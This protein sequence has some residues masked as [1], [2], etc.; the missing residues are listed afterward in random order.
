MSR[1]QPCKRRNFVRKLRALGFE[2]PYSGA[3]HQFLVHGSH[4]LTIPSNAEYSV[5]QLRM[6][7]RQAEAVLGREISPAEWIR[8]K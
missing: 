6:M 5:S 4:R 3:R 7:V 8:L 1:W 2:G